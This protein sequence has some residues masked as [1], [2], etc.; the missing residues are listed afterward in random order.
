MKRKWIKPLDLAIAGAILLLGLSLLLVMCRRPMG[1][2]AR[3]TVNGELYAELSLSDAP[4]DDYPVKTE[5]GNLHLCVTKEG[6]FVKDS[7]CPDGLCVRTGSIARD[8]ESIVCAPLGVCITVGKSSLDGV[9][10]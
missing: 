10:G 2:T 4:I 5:H 6:L 3:V 8:G 9:T 1:D 7:D